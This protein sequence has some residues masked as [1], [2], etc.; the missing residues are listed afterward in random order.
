MF[1]KNLRRLQFGCFSFFSLMKS[2]GTLSLSK[3]K[4]FFSFPIF[5]FILAKG[6]QKNHRSIIEKKKY[7]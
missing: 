2:K 5:S 1:F 7:A 3:S 4:I 6:V